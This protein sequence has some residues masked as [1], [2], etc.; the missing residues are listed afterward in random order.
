MNKRPKGS[1]IAVVAINMMDSLVLTL[2]DALNRTEL[3]DALPEQVVALRRGTKIITERMKALNDMVDTMHPTVRTGESGPISSGHVTSPYIIGLNARKL[4]NKLIDDVELWKKP[5]N[6]KAGYFK[7]G[8]VRS[9]CKAFDNR[10]GLMLIESLS[11]P[12]ACQDWLD[13]RSIK[14]R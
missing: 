9:V 1:K 10:D 6:M 5:E 3:E 2:L 8:V 13:G 7:I 12:E 11:G 4:F 14:R